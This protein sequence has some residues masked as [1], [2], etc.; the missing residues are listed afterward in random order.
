MSEKL[1]IVARK[2][3]KWLVFLLLGVVMSIGVIYGYFASQTGELAT[4]R[5]VFQQA[6]SPCVLVFAHRGG[7][8]LFPE[9]TLE[10]FDYSAKMGADV[11][12][13]DIHATADGTLVVMHDATVQRTTDGRGRVSEMTLEAVKK[14]DAALRL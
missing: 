9:N 7:G 3:I 14:L 6:N 4:E 13:L 1:R 12:E 2:I 8:G 11:L 5:A 10:A